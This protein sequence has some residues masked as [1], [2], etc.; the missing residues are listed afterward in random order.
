MDATTGPFTMLGDP[1]ADACEDDFCAVPA[2]P[3]GADKARVDQTDDR[4]N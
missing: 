1:N 4:Q 2:V 3:T